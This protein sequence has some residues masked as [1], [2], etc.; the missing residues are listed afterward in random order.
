MQAITLHQFQIEQSYPVTLTEPKEVQPRVAAILEHYTSTTPYLLTPEVVQ[1]QRV[2]RV[3]L[4]LLLFEQPLTSD[5]Q[6]AVARSS[7]IEE[8][9]A[10]H[11]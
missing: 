5:R 8:L 3:T 4:H 7:G 11:L 2:R 1:A 6:D 9:Q 10:L